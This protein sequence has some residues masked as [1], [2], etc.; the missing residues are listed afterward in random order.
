MHQLQL[1]VK[2]QRSQYMRISLFPEVMSP[3]ITT[4]F[5][6]SY[7]ASHNIIYLLTKICVKWYP[8]KNTKKFVD[9]QRE[10]SSKVA[11]VK[12]LLLIQFYTLWSVLRPAAVLFLCS[13]FHTS[14][15]LFHTYENLLQQQF[16]KKN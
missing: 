13:D 1:N 12:I 5:F 16:C 4:Y 10:I 11:H 3:V 9:R 6:F 15:G 7:V 8:K 14:V 2:G